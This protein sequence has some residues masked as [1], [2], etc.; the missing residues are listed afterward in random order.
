MF[1]GLRATLVE[2][3]DDGLRLGDRAL[4]IGRSLGDLG[5]QAGA[6]CYL[7]IAHLFAGRFA[8]AA[9]LCEA[10]IALIPPER[11]HERFGQARMVANL[12][13]GTLG[14]ALGRQGRFS[15]GIAHAKEALKI[16]LDAGQAYSVSSSLW[17]LGVLHLLKGEHAEATREIQQSIEVWRTIQAP[18]WNHPVQGL[19]LV[20]CRMGRVSEG[21]ALIDGAPGGG[22]FF[23]YSTAAVLGEAYLLA[24]RANDAAN[25]AQKTLVR[26]REKGQ[27]AFEADALHLAAE[28]AAQANP[29]DLAAAEL[30]YCASMTLADELGMRPL[31]AHCHLGLGKLYHRTDKREQAQE[32]LAT[33]TSMYRDMGMTYWLEKAE[34]EMTQPGG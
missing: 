15:D 8:E 16:A 21:I 6:S 27:R 5:I 4:A 33:A 23:H 10:A 12:A 18:A 14:N 3:L 34:A 24:G 1:A 32:H 22:A 29:P 9:R 13:R 30:Q 25:Q 20:Y 11:T 7:A 26:A 17:E 28:V 2:D 19:G 31:I